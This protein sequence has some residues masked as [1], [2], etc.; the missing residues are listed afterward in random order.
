MTP[1]TL[2]RKL[3]ELLDACE[4][5][6]EFLQ[7]VV[8]ALEDMYH[9]DDGESARAF[10]LLDKAVEAFEEVENLDDDDDDDDDDDE[11]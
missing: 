5:S 2:K 8:G 7:G 1:A 11:G 9:D 3:A 6:A 4:S 10:E